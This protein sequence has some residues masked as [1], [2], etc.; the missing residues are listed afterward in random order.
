MRRRPH[1][2]LRRATFA[3]A[4]VLLAAAAAV[5]YFSGEMIDPPRPRISESA[6][7]VLGVTVRDD[8]E[9]GVRVVRAVA[10]AA[11][12]GIRP[13]DRIVR[14]DG[15]EILDRGDLASRV[16]EAGAGRVLTIEARR[17]DG[18]V[19]ADVT[20]AER[21]VSPADQG[22][23]WEEVAF[24]GADG[25]VVRGWFVPPASGGAEAPPFPAVAYGHGN[26]SD[27][28][29]FLSLAWDVHAAGIGQLLI[30]F[31]G[32]GE[33]EGEVITLGAR[34]ARDLRASLDTLASRPGVDPRRLGIVGRSMG[35]VAAILEAEEDER[36]IALVLDSPFADL[37]R[38][39]DEE[40]RRRLPGIGPLLVP[41]V[42]RVAGWRAGYDPWSVRPVDSIARVHAPT[43]LIHGTED[44]VVD[45][46]HARDLARAAGGP[47]RLRMVDGVGH[48]DVRPDEVN[49]EIVGF[50]RQ[51]LVVARG[52]EPSA[53]AGLLPH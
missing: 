3:G 26:A 37:P 18:G 25:L 38:I 6:R 10:P 29:H 21:P 40:A 5:V 41:A 35:A 1:P 16:R 47:L 20:V 12:A 27:R 42:L 31:S 11:D 52:V 15:E 50:L 19:L 28:T 17:G 4:I 51:H 34:E 46:A 36:V 9:G 23:P 8:D 22:L 33:S 14:V 30:D 2:A 49:D 44:D 53:N 45:P 32:R 39:V 13:G 48:N 43:L 7:P 24:T